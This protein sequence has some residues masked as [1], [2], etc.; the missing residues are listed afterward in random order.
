M[1]HRNS[2]PSIAC[3]VTSCAYHCKDQNH[4]SLN[5]IK[6]GCCDPKVTDCTATE[7]ASFHLG[8]CEHCR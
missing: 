1:E 2:N 4:C 6:V 3:T 7:C 5:E 8:G